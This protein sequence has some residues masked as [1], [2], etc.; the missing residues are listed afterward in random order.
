MRIGN[1]FPPLKAILAK[2]NLKHTADLIKYAIQ[3]GY[4]QIAH[5]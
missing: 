3:K 4:V 2:L 1:S 5:R